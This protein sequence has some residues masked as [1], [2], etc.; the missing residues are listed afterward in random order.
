LPRYKSSLTITNH[1]N[2]ILLL[3]MSAQQKIKNS[4]FNSLIKLN[5]FWSYHSSDITEKAIN[6]EMFI[7]KALVHLDIEDLN[8]L[9]CLFPYKK[10][11]EVWKNQLCIQEPYFHELNVLLAYLYFNI[12]DPDRYLKKINNRHIQSL[13]QSSDEW[14]NATYGKNF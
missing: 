12:K 10:I 8:K 14:F 11:K 1:L 2:F 4:L 5:A 9:F 6:D 3:S 13:K 7:E